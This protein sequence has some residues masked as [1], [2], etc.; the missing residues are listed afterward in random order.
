MHVADQRPLGVRQIGD[1]GVGRGEARGGGVGIPGILR[2]DVVVGEAEKRDMPPVARVVL[3]AVHQQEAARGDGIRTGAEIG[4]VGDA[5]LFVHHQGLHDVQVLGACLEREVRRGVAVRAA[6]IH[7][8]VQVAAPPPV[9]REVG[10]PLDHDA[11]RDGARGADR[12]VGVCDAVLRP[13]PH[14]DV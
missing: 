8:H 1:V 5:L 11:S 6:V 10:E 12:E 7:V 13:V 14:L 2:E 9:R 4:D 3:L